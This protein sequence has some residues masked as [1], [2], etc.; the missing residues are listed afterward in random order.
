MAAQPASDEMLKE[1]DETVTMTTLNHK[2]DAPNPNKRAFHVSMACPSRSAPPL[3]NASA[4]FIIPGHEISNPKRQKR[5]AIPQQM[6]QSPVLPPTLQAVPWHA[7][8]RPQHVS[9]NT[10]LLHAAGV[11]H[12]QAAVMPQQMLQ[13]PEYPSAYAVQPQARKNALAP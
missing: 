12:N 7:T 1:V 9:Q 11:A 8:A 5:A 3:P 10:V 2:E 6:L 13:S 4:S